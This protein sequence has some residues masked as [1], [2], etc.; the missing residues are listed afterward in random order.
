MKYKKITKRYTQVAR[1]LFR[2]ARGQLPAPQPPVS[3]DLW[4]CKN[5]LR[6]GNRHPPKMQLLDSL[7]FFKAGLYD[8]EVAIWYGEM[9]RVGKW[10]WPWLDWQ[11]YSI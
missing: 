11:C 6:G 7:L 9:L 10:S 2:F 8:L 5:S 1:L 3:S 4:G